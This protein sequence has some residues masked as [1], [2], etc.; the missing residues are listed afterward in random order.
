[1]LEAGSVPF[2]TLMSSF[3]TLPKSQKKR[4]REDGSRSGPVKKSKPAGAK[5][6][7][8]EERD[9]SI[10][11]SEDGSI[12]SGGQQ[13]REESSSEDETA[14]ERRLRLAEQYLDKLKG[15]VQDE[16]GFDA[17][18]IDRDL[19]AE[20]LQEDVAE[21]KGRLYKHIASE[22]DFANAIQTHFR[23]RPTSMYAIATCPPYAYTACRDGVVTKWKLPDLQKNPPDP[24]KKPQKPQKPTRRRPVNVAEVRSKPGRKVVLHHSAPVLAIAVSSDGKYIATGSVDKKLILY[25]TS[26]PNELTPVKAFA[27]HRDSITSL[28]FR[29]GS[30]QLFSASKDRTVKVWSAAER[31][32]VETLF[33]HQDEVVDIAAFPTA[34]RCASVGAR[35]R[36]ARIWKVVEETQLV[37]RGGGG[38]V[39][40]TDRNLTNGVPDTSRERKRYAEG[41]IDRVVVVDNETFV[42]GS[43]N[44][45]LC[46]W[47][48]HKKKPVFTVP[49]AHGLEE[50]ITADDYSA[51]I[52]HAPALKLPEPQPRWITAL[53]ALPL[54][55]LIITGS[56]DGQ[57]RIWKIGEGKRTLESLGSLRQSDQEA[58]SLVRGVVND[59]D[60]YGVGERGKDGIFVVAAIGK[61]HRLGRWKKTD[62][63]GG[64]IFWE[65]RRKKILKAKVTE[66]S[67]IN[68]H[69][70][71]SIDL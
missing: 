5:A 13:D 7:S 60:V 18:D 26:A 43:D 45:N 57:I 11:G 14:A 21:S 56:W 53:R 54:S 31:A 58:S 71:K 61:E 38:G 16:H 22:F 37:F 23:T 33:G 65:I 68:G 42:T 49:L 10:S 52:E 9:E 44:G 29:Q 36:T 69:A 20:R 41:S 27:H 50:Q 6:K 34:E 25:S 15:E 28:S 63:R 62:A 32:Y 66:R 4:K 70:A 2:I 64:A 59:I 17:E 8:R 1:M 67:G 12:R 24:H 30:T 48:L 40:K 51:E 55:D 3:F 35:D 46:L 19:I 47:N 39:T